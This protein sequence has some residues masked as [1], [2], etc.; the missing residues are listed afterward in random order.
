MQQ[1][2]RGES[3]Q[4]MLAAGRV[5]AIFRWLAEEERRYANELHQA[6]LAS[7][8]S[9]DLIVCGHTLEPRCRAIAAARGIAILPVFLC[10]LTPSR[11]FPSPLL[12][13]RNLGPL[14]RFSHELPFQMAW[15]AQRD[16]LAALHR[17][18]GLAPPT[19]R[20]WQYGYSGKAPL[21]LGYSSALSPP[22]D[23]WPK[24]LRAVGPLTPWP[25]LRERFGQ[26]GIPAELE[27]WLKAGSPPVFL[28]F[29]SMPV[30]DAGEMLGTVREALGNVG[31]RG[32]LAAG[33]SELSAVGDDTLFIASGELDHQSLLPRCAAAVHHGGAGTTAASV[34]AGAPTLACGVMFDQHYWGSRCRKLGIGDTFPFTKLDTRRLTRGLRT[35][36][37]P[38]VAARAKRVGQQVAEENGV[39]ATVAFVEQGVELL[40]PAVSS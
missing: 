26:V 1:M 9:A 27:D 37:D 2:F 8:E 36:L 23:D 13:Q 40:R 29:G 34:G 31:A 38:Q 21:L 16:A 19:Q 4:R 10:P 6:L 25:E 24:R 39:E 22:P 32:I 11:R 35:V 5:N 3:A 14:N 12:T 7:T 33:W 20:Q 18:L 15:R 30:L 17:E 28:G